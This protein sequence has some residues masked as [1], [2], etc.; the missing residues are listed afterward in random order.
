MVPLQY[1]QVIIYDV[2]F[3]VYNAYAAS[4]Y[5]IQCLPESCSKAHEVEGP[6]LILD[7]II[8]SNEEWVGGREGGSIGGGAALSQELPQVDT[9][10]AVDV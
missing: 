4:L 1:C 7:S 8:L 10:E 3:A 6:S 5:P 9:K 2:F